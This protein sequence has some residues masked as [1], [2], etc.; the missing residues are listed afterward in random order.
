MLGFFDI[1]QV[2]NSI[3]FSHFGEV[4]YWEKGKILKN[5]TKTN[6][7]LLGIILSFFYLIILFTMAIIQI[8]YTSTDE[9]ELETYI[10][11][12]ITSTFYSIVIFVTFLGISFALIKLLNDYLVEVSESFREYR[13]NETLGY[14]M[15]D[16]IKDTIYWIYKTVDLIMS[17]FIPGIIALFYFGNHKISDFVEGITNLVI[18]SLLPTMIL[19]K[20]G[21]YLRAFF[22]DSLEIGKLLLRLIKYF[23]KSFIR[24][25]TNIKVRTKFLI[26]KMIGKNK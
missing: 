26:D 25:I 14:T 17:I 8:P 9:I 15:E 10:I 7:S 3:F 22:L 23:I 24:G 18:M 11:S 13:D 20:I 6:G 21:D 12:S 1:L 5:K 16:G 2:H 19:L 4:F